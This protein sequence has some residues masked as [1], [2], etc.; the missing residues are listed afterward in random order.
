MSLLTNEVPLGTVS[1][2]GAENMNRL[3][4]KKE[5]RAYLEAMP[6]N[7]TVGVSYS[8]HDNLF[9]RFFKD[10]DPARHVTIRGNY[11]TFDGV[12][13][14]NGNKPWVRKLLEDMNHSAGFFMPIP[15]RMALEALDRAE[16]EG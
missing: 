11:A 1:V 7:M 4:S 3:P 5:L 14:T 8:P 16:A 15:Q 13:R 2:N 12:K 6:P 9:S 10:Q